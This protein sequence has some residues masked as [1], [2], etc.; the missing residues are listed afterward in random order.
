V[1]QDEAEIIRRVLAGDRAAFGVLVERYQDRIYSLAC[2]LVRDVHAAEDLAQEAFVRAFQHLDQFRGQSEFSTWLYRITSNVCWGY[3]RG[4]GRV[5]PAGA[6]GEERDEAVAAAARSGPSVEELAEAEELKNRLWEAIGR[7]PEV[8]RTALVLRYVDDLSYAE[9]ARVLGV[10]V[11]TV[12]TRLYRARELLARM[13]DGVFP[14][15]TD[16]R[17]LQ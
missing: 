3:L 17:A 11:A 14:E 1:P 12:G 10:P 2:H 16:F 8:Y 15:A 7:L 4:Q 13:L 9:M 5:I 6:A